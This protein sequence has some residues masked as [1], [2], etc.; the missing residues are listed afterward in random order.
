MVMRYGMGETLAAGGLRGG[1]RILPRAAVR[2]RDALRCSE[3]TAR[4]IDVAVRDLVESQ[5]QRARAMLANNR[6]LLDEG[7]STLLAKETLAGAELDGILGR[8]GREAG[9]RIAAA[10]S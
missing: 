9:P 3:A 2:G 6:P 10:A 5:F 8:V 7:A 1:A 4:E